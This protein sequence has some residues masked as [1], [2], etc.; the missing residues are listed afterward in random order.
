MSSPG[1]AQLLERD[2]PLAED[3]MSVSNLMKMRAKAFGGSSSSLNS[4]TD[5]HQPQGSSPLA[6]VAGY[7]MF[8]TDGRASSPAGM[9][10]K[11]L[12]IVESEEEEDDRTGDRRTLTQNTPMKNATE[13]KR[14]TSSSSREQDVP[15]SP[16]SRKGNHSRN[17]SGAESVSYARESDGRWVLERRRT[18]DAGELELIGREYLA[19]ARI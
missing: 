8:P 5:R 7:R 11:H 1:I 16:I 9:L 17:S 3:E 14:D 4:L 10:H 19:G 15:G 6:H 12:N 2:S 13:P 18:G